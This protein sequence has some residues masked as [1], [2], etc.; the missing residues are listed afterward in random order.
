MPGS[1]PRLVISVG[2]T[3]KS[4]ELANKHIVT[5]LIDSSGKRDGQTGY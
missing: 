2:N 5:L 3:P 4:V 1:K